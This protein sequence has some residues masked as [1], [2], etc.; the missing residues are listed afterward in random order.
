[1]KITS[2]GHDPDLGKKFESESEGLVIG[3]ARS[4]PQSS[5]AE[6]SKY[7]DAQEQHDQAML[8]ADSKLPEVPRRSQFQTQ[9]EYDEALAGWRSRAGRIRGL[10]VGKKTGA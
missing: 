3:R 6:T 2:K 10:R 9:M 1:M 8:E 4:L 7:L 5:G